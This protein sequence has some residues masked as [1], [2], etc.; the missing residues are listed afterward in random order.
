MI[1]IFNLIYTNRLRCNTQTAV[2]IEVKKEE[3]EDGGFTLRQNAAG[4]PVQP[5]QVKFKIAAIT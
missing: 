3:F 1:D 4:I 5:T 2:M